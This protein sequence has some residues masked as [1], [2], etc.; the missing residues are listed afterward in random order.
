MYKTLIKKSFFDGWDNILFL[1]LSNIVFAALIFAFFALQ[2]T[3][4]VYLVFL[5]FSIHFCGVN[6]AAFNITHEQKSC[7][8]G[9][10]SSIK[11]VGHWVLFYFVFSICFLLIFSITPIY[12]GQGDI[13][14]YSIGFFVFFAALIVALNL[15]FY[16]PLAL[17]LKNDKPLKTLKKCFLVFFDNFIFSVYCILKDICD[18]T[19]SILTAFLMPGI[20]GVAVTHNNAVLFFMLR[21]DW[22]E[23]KKV[24]KHDVSSDM[25]LKPLQENL[26]NRNLGTLF[27]PWKHR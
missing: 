19:I 18:L 16:F 24:G 6:G 14:W 22:M 9:Y 4:F 12:M 25:Y 17:S 27:F 21:Y 20:S 3:Y 10:L 5:V 15:F 1:F 13:I 11:K 23:E 2:Q 7:F 26:K 8:K